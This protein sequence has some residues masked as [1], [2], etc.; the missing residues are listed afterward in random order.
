MTIKMNQSALLVSQ[1]GCGKTTLI[2]HLAN[3]MNKKLYVFNM[4]LGSDVADLVGGFKPIDCKLM[5]K[6]LLL[7]FIKYFNK[8]P[9][10]KNNEK[11]L[12]GLVQFS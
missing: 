6:K 5:I 4:N 3:I 2:Q 7:K 8:I 9:S 12:N 1:T 10:D 11:F